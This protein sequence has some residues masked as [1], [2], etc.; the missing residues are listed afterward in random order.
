MT[1]SSAVPGTKESVEPGTDISSL[2]D[3]TKLPT[4]HTKLPTDHT[5]LPTEHT[6][7]P[8]EST[9]TEKYFSRQR[10]QRPIWQQEPESGADATW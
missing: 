3:H 9:T 5:K 4:D 8:A 1:S 6:G 7:Q 10:P 2:T